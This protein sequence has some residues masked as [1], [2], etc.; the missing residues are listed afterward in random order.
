MGTTTTTITGV[1]VASATAAA[2]GVFTSTTHG[3]TTGDA[4]L[5]EAMDEM[6]E[7]NSQIFDIL[8]IDANSFNIRSVG[9]VAA[10]NL[11]TAAFTAE[12]TGGTAS[13]GL[14]DVLDVRVRGEEI[15]WTLTGTWVATI[16]LERETAPNSD[17]W[18]EITR[19]TANTAFTFA[20]KRDQERFRTR[21]ITWTSGTATVVLADAAHISDSFV[22]DDG[23]EYMEVTED[24][25]TFRDNV[26]IDGTLTTTGG[27]A[28]GT[29]D[30]IEAGD[31]SLGINGLD[32][33]Q[34][35]EILITGGTSSTAGNAGGQVISTG[36]TP[37]S[38]GVGGL[39][40][41]RGGIGGSAS[42]TG[43]AASLI[44]G[45]G[46]AGNAEGG[47]ATGRGG[48]GQGSGAGGLGTYQ[49]GIA[50]A[51][52]TGGAA[53]LLGGAGGVTSGAG[54]A[55]TVTTGAGQGVGNSVSGAISLGTGIT[56]NATSETASTTGLIDLRS[57]APGTATTGTGGASGALLLRS[58][59]GAAATGAA[60][61]GGASGDLTISTG[62]GGK[63][64]STT[65]GGLGGNAGDI[66]IRPGSGGVSDG[67]VG[68]IG[69]DLTI[70]AGAGGE[71]T[72]T[73][74]NGGAAG[75]L[76]LA[77]GAGG[78][79]ADATPGTGGAVTLTGGAGAATNG[80]GG[81]VTIEGGLQNGS[82]AAGVVNLGTVNTDI[83]NL[84]HAASTLT[85]LGTQVNTTQPAFLAY[86]SVTDAN[87]TGAG[88]VATVD[89]DTEVFD[90][91][92]DFAT[93]TF[94][95]PV[96]GRY[97]LSATVQIEGLLDATDIDLILVTS[98]RS[99][100]EISI[101]G[102]FSQTTQTTR[103]T[104]VADMDASDT[105]TVTI[106]VTGEGGGD[107]VD[108]IGGASALTHFSGCLLT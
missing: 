56:A 94:T 77:A 73:G 43:G 75:V 70:T 23:T 89:F 105:V 1:T 39:V 106:E 60:G 28:T 87:A 59:A 27:S 61:V 34:G 33:A 20:T 107:I 30:V 84:G 25:V 64:D 80:D 68:G 66:L 55:A 10:G 44:G 57:G 48:T 7:V 58:A 53:Q 3:F 46:T 12:T 69:G 41:L 51:T 100:Q 88:T 54:G 14:G 36:G 81:A 19:T 24:A 78:I 32:A 71:A 90:Q 95:A 74:D 92:A 82:G 29:F 108:V 9:A 65:D 26:I 5:L 103:I 83:V 67:D 8:R 102:V 52:G 49:G 79:S 72:A 101:L 97:L 13:L 96:A 2:P 47:I 16:A 50:G 4:V 99:Y 11:S 18:V 45:T 31:A 38:T 40:E 104:A 42:G 37:G 91:G 22:H 6:T 62:A 21:T 17:V 63:A 35:G 85:F 76:A 15:T 86:N 98:N 93:D